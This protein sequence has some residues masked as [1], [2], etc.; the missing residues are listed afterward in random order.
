MMFTMSDLLAEQSEFQKTYVR[1]KY[2]KELEDLTDSERHEI[3]KQQVLALGS[4]VFEFLNR[5]TNWKDHRA[6]TT[7][8]REA[9]LEEYVDIGKYWLNL[10]IYMN[11][12]PGEFLKVFESKSRTVEARWRAEMEKV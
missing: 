7:L 11:I 4:E 1:W 8:D 9:A 2:K 10:F 3:I 12:S 5:A 6:A